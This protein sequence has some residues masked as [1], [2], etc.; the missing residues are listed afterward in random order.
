M[1]ATF[2]SLRRLAPRARS[3]VLAGVCVGMSSACF[4]VGAHA[5]T[6]PTPLDMPEPPPR[7]V[8]V[9]EP[10]V[11]RPISLPEEPVRNTPTRPRPTPPPE[12]VRPPETPKPAEPSVDPAKPEEAPRPPTTLQITPTQR[13][14][15][16]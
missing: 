10:D 6:A 4:G 7:V 12:P 15:E 5:V 13:E 14:E 2:T 8:E 3:L 1:Y 16:V 9:H 11:P